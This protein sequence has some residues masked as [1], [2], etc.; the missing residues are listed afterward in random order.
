MIAGDLGALALP[1]RRRRIAL[2]PRSVAGRPWRYADAE[3]YY[4]Q[5]LAALAAFYGADHFRP[6][7]AMTMLGRALIYQK[8]FDEGVP[9]ART[10]A[11]DPGAR[12]RPTTPPAAGQN[13]RPPG[14]RLTREV[15]RG[16]CRAR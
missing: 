11:G 13:F 3:T 14:S 16:R 6:A 10:G 5:V 1:R 7:S 4:R 12:E 2:Q 8:S 9:A 15:R